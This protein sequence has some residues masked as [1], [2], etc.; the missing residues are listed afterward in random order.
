[1]PS[2]AELLRRIEV[3]ESL[4]I[5]LTDQFFNNAARREPVLEKELQRAKEEE[6]SADTLAALTKQ[7]EEVRVQISVLPAIARRLGPSLEERQSRL[8]GERPGVH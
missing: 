4:L 7:L 3:I 1:M 5:G 6:A 2:N 8:S